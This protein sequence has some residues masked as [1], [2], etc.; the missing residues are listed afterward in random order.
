MLFC[1]K[2]VYVHRYSKVF[3]TVWQ[4]SNTLKKLLNFLK[5]FLTIL[6]KTF[7]L[8]EFSLEYYFPL[9]Y[10]KDLEE[11]SE[12]SIKILNFSGANGASTPR[13]GS[14]LFSE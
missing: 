4:N 12:L 1:S 9:N 5:N 13:H 8:T 11:Y 2:V 6:L 7:F 14:P 10:F 3:D